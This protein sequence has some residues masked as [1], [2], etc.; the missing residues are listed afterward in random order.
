[1]ARH[2]FPGCATLMLWAT[3]AVAAL[4]EPT[5]AD[6]GSAAE[7]ATTR[8]ARQIH[9]T[10]PGELTPVP[11]GTTVQRH[12]YNATTGE[13]GP[14]DGVA[15][16]VDQ[17]TI[18][19]ANAP[20]THIL[21]P[22]AFRF[23]ADDMRS[24]AI[25]GCAL[26][27]F[28]F[29]IGGVGQGGLFTVDFALLDDCPSFGGQV[30]PGTEGSLSGLADNALHL[31]EVAFDTP[32][33][34]P[35]SFWFTVTFDS[36][37][38]G[39]L[40]GT[41][42]SIG[43]TENTFDFI[44]F[45]CQAW[46][47]IPGRY[48]GFHLRTFCEL[49]FEREFL[50]YLNPELDGPVFFP[51]TGQW[52]VDDLTLI[53]DDCVLSSYEIAGQDN[54]P[55]SIQAQLRTSCNPASMI[56]GTQGVAIGRGDDTPE[57]LRFDFPGGVPLPPGDKF[58]IAWRYTTNAAAI[59][60]EEAQLG[61]TD[62]SFG[63]DPD[64]CI[65]T[66]RTLFSG[67]NITL[68][69]L[70]N[71][72]L[73]SCCDL[74]VGPPGTGVGELCREVKEIACTSRLARYSR[75]MK[76]PGSC[77]INS[78]TCAADEDCTDLCSESGDPCPLGTECEPGE[79]CDPQVCTLSGVS[80]DPPC[81]YSACC[82]PPDENGQGEG[83][84]DRPFVETPDADGN[85]V[86]GC[87]EI[88]D[89]DVPP[90]AAAWQQAQFCNVGEQ[91]CIIWACRFA[92]GACDEIHGNPGCNFPSCCD[93]ICTADAFC[94][95]F[96]WDLSCV[97]QVTNPVTGCR[98]LPAFNDECADP[99]DPLKGALL[100]N[101]CSGSPAPGRVCEVAIDD[102]RRCD[103][104][105]NSYCLNSSECAGLCLESGETCDA[106]SITEMSTA[107]GTLAE[108]GSETFC[109]H[110]AG[111][112]LPGVGPIWTKFIASE[113]SV[114]LDTC[115][116]AGAL[117]TDSILE[118]YAVDQGVSEVEACASRR[119][120]A[121]NDDGGC[122]HDHAKVCVHGLTI[123][124]VYYVQLAAKSEDT[125]GKF[126]LKLRSPCTEPQPP[127]NNSCL[128]AEP[129]PFGG[130]AAFDLVDATPECPGHNCVFDL[131]SDVWFEYT[132]DLSGLVTIDTC[133]ST[134]ETSLVVYTPGG[135]PISD[136]RRLQDGCNNGAGGACGNGSVVTVN[137]LVGQN[138][139]IRVGGKNGEEP[140]GLLTVGTIRPDCNLNGR[141]DVDDIACGRDFS[142]GTCTDTGAACQCALASGAGCQVE[143]D[144]MCATGTCG[145]MLPG[146]DDCNGNDV[147][148]ECDIASGFS[149]DCDLNGTPDECQD[150]PPC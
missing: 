142:C 34:I 56:P 69:C 47:G 131:D 117:I 120:I 87:S 4:P 101:R 141:D 110:S 99:D 135:C 119:A 11:R 8:D 12:Y 143:A 32:I 41:P 140:T 139:L 92:P 97:S 68:R 82:E 93:Q 57:I 136:E 150:P 28:E 118:V 65:F 108:D 85:L 123:G 26:T 73:G 134:F 27:G 124:D 50:A 58:W 49:P 121:C 1:M 51:G 81:G 3:T 103:S 22:G 100:L 80:F 55:F 148:D 72:P 105:L 71:A 147:P 40:V 10:P 84:T 74:G 6:T 31:I 60:A 16:G 35:Q 2:L 38:V 86:T 145:N 149:E 79:T 128:T 24:V 113:T 64:G 130:I 77:S 9:D 137:V 98:D 129:V 78:D 21:R 18:S 62:D 43:F 29:M 127:S 23:L 59:I 144:A 33:Q 66:F 146:S 114:V 44:G 115:G 52:I 88:F 13:S 45:N 91:H 61:S 70:G 126:Q 96:N 112:D 63:L 94:C 46:T 25:G 36:N 116:T 7:S 104:G 75:G 106:S 5:S 42:A 19:Y 95:L 83:C 20:P 67:F 107:G 111:V 30:V 90:H 133:G 138:Y 76:C 109:C 122:A 37:L 89:T 102:C 53:V 14:L 54:I 15:G 39:W 17:A 48:G 132:A 125:G